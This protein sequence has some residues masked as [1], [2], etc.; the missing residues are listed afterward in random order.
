MRSRTAGH[1]SR[2]K[3]FS[4]IYSESPN[5]TS[6]FCAVMTCGHADKSCPVVKGCSRRVALLYEDPK[7][8]DDTPQ[9]AAGYDERCRQI[10]REMLYLFAKVSV[11][12]TARSN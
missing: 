9:E 8:F 1:G 4:K 3:A 11:A 12:N 6:D 2:I 7:K 5:P 10:C